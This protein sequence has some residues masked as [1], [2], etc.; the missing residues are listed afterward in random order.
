MGRC[1]MDQHYHDSDQLCH[2]DSDD[3]AVHVLHLP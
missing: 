3:S 2:R 1:K